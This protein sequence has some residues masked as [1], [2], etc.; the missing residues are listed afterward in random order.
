MLL[1][2]FALA[3]VLLLGN[4]ASQAHN[5]VNPQAFCNWQIG[6]TATSQKIGSYEVQRHWLVPASGCVLSITIVD[7]EPDVKD[8]HTFSNYWIEISENS[9]VKSTFKARATRHL[10][11]GMGGSSPKDHPVIAHISD[12]EYLDWGISAGVEFEHEGKVLVLFIAFP[13]AQPF[14][15]ETLSKKQDISGPLD[16]SSQDQ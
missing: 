5:V 7:G 3:C 4:I 2:H 11:F 10:S 1:R 8:G 16:K 14:E 6:D 12:L 13:F 15:Q 9:P